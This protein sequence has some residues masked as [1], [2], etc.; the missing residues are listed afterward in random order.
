MLWKNEKGETD[1]TWGKF[2]RE[3]ARPSI[4]FDRVMMHRNG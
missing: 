3:W 2:S 4:Y 1:R